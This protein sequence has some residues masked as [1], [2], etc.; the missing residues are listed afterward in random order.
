MRGLFVLALIATLTTT[1]SAV[2]QDLGEFLASPAELALS[3]YK[4]FIS[5]AKGSACPMEPSDSTYASQAIRRYGIFWGSL[6]TA[7]RLHRCGHDG[8]RYAIVRTA[9]G[10]K[11]FDPVDPA[12]PRP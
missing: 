12:D 9:R 7:D 3:I 6:M 5:P 10:L 1:G 2:E 4:R 8:D 11:Y